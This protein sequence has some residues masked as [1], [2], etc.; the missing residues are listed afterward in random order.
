MIALPVELNIFDKIMVGGTIIPDLISA[1]IKDREILDK[2]SQIEQILYALWSYWS[3]TKDTDAK[4]AMEI[5][6]NKLI[7]EMEKAKSKK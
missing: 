5:F 6:Q 3:N 2:I 1:G 7:K 4:L